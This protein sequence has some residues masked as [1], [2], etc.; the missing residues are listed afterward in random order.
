MTFHERI[1]DIHRFLITFRAPIS[2]STP[3]TY[4]STRPFLPSQS[5]LST[6]FYGSFTKCI[7]VERG[8]LLTWPA[9]PLQ[10]SGHRRDI[11]CLSYSPDGCYIITGSRDGE[12]R[13]WDAA[14]GATV[15]SHLGGHMCGVTSIAYSPNGRYII[16]GGMTGKSKSGMLRLA[17]E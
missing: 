5:P 7:Q 13:V 11:N 1:K 16:S 8:Q 4:V 6:A 12:I 10:W 9:P 3:H 14:T 17:L 15:D 2:V